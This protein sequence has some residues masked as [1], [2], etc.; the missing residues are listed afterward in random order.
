MIRGKANKIEFVG[1]ENGW[2]LHVDTNVETFC[3]YIH[4]LAWDLAAHADQTLGAW[5]REG[6]NARAVKLD[7]DA[8]DLNDPKRIALEQELNR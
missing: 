6:E 4:G 2:E 1:D 3:F 7:L 5:R 8:Y